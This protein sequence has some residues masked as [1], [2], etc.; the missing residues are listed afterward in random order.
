V[1]P[2]G[3][4]ITSLPA[5]DA[6][7]LADAALT[8]PEPGATAGQFPDGYHQLRETT[9]IGS[10]ADCLEAAGD[11]LLHWQVQLRAGLRVAASAP[12]VSPGAVVR[13]GWRAGPV[14]VTAPCRVVYVIS[15]PRR[16]GFAYG[17][18]PGHPESGEESFW[19]DM[20]ADGTVTFTI[21]AFSRP[22]TLAARAG[23]PVALRV[24]R[25]ITGRYLA[26]LQ[27]CGGAA[28]TG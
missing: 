8:Y 27:D 19:V 3:L 25:R 28:A 24:Q 11:A 9:A 16:R 18:L 2:S 14:T 17:T 21:A 23:R 7:R 6:A 13:L 15:E 26:A 5:A 10:G 22:A 12:V 20:Q 4:S 1:T